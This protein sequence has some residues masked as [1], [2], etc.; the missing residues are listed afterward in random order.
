MEDSKVEKIKVIYVAGPYSSDT[1]A[2]VQANINA[3]EVVA[4]IMTRKGFATILPHKITAFWDEDPL[5][6]DMKHT[7][8]MT[9]VCLPLLDKC[10][11]I[12]MCTGWQD[13]PGSVI[14]HQHA[15]NRGMPIFYHVE[16]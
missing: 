1:R 7:D 13:S 2:G 3:A 5:F 6:S 14:E 8:W 10:D 11:A 16:G 4:K 9:Q 15:S 12:V